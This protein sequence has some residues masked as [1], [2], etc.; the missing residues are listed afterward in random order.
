MEIGLQ[1]VSNKVNNYLK[2]EY[3]DD[4]G[5]SSY[6]RALASHA[7]GAGFDSQNLHILNLFYLFKV[8]GWAIDKR[9]NGGL[10]DNNRPEQ[11]CH[12]LILVLLNRQDRVPVE[13]D[14]FG[15]DEEQV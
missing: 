10:N 1:N 9:W 14:D 8:I 15:F 6:G 2:L 5:F 4:R 11:F 7:R 3:R 13:C 12:L